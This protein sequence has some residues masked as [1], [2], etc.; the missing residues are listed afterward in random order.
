MK[1][2][3][4]VGPNIPRRRRLRREREQKLRAERMQAIED[5]FERQKYAS[6]TFV[7]EEFSFYTIS[8]PILFILYLIR[9][10]VFSLGNAIIR[11]LK[12]EEDEL[13]TQKI[14]NILNTEKIY[15]VY[16]IKLSSAMII[17]KNKLYIG[18]KLKSFLN[19]DEILSL[20][21]QLILIRSPMKTLKRGE[22][23][24]ESLLK[25]FYF[26]PIMLAFFNIIYST[27]KGFKERI[28]SS[29]MRNMIY[30][31]IAQSLT[32]SGIRSIEKFAKNWIVIKSSSDIVRLGFEKPFKSA[33]LKIKE[34]NKQHIRKI[35]INTEIDPNNLD[36]SI[37]LVN[38]RLEEIKPI[39][40]PFKKA[41]L[42]IKFS[43]E[44]DK[45]LKSQK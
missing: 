18:D 6:E 5:K 19:D 14:N 44:L 24:S 23:A 39:K 16:W 28:K 1:I 2:N 29:G 37:K 42:M 22:I 38:K 11:T 41:I 13:L 10:Y 20:L 8:I 15:K 43:K 3:E 35:K 21:L 32:F 33:M 45:L 4:L 30:L 9:D 27:N 25:S 12:S 26:M 17:S 34:H 7:N 36:E 31:I 40:N